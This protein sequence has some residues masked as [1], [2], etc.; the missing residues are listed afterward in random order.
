MVI[1]NTS[2]R[3]NFIQFVL[4]NISFLVEQTKP[5]LNIF[6]S[7]H[8]DTV[9]TTRVYIELTTALPAMRTVECPFATAYWWHQCVIP[10]RWHPE[11]E[12]DRELG[13]HLPQVQV[14]W[15]PQLGQ[16]QQVT[17]EEDHHLLLRAHLGRPF[18]LVGSRASFLCS[19]AFN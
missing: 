4:W 19:C 14:L 8:I 10:D 3:V 5:T 18:Q 16:D 12:A 11:T 1:C 6:E 2:N 15:P 7:L 13:P 17:P 9:H